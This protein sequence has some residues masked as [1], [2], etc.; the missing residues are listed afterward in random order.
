MMIG[1]LKKYYRSKKSGNLLTQMF[2]KIPL[3]IFLSGDH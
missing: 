3:L 1:K 2:S